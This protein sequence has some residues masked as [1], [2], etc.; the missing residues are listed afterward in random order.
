MAGHAYSLIDL[1][2][3]THEDERVRLCKLR[4]P[5]G[6]GEWQGDWSD[7]SDKWTDELRE[8]YGC[9]D[10]DDG[11]FFMTFEDYMSHFKRTS[12]CLQQEPETYSHKQLTVEFT[13]DDALHSHPEL[14]RIMIDEDINCDE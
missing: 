13:K 8:T 11:L 3:F 2:E 10:K 6:H 4:N 9:H 5:W 14:F 7:K 12:V 1:Y